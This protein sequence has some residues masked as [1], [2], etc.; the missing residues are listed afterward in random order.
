MRKGVAVATPPL[1]R[2]AWSC[3][4]CGHTGGEAQT[5]FPVEPSMRDG[6]WPV[7]LNQ[8]RKKLVRVHQKRHGCA[9]IPQDFVIGR[10]RG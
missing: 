5:T 2:V 4:R 7:M 6:M 1:V 9:A 10:W 8:L 3:S